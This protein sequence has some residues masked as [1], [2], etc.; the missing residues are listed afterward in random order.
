MDVAEVMVEL[1]KLGTEQTKKTWLR[2]GASG[3][4]FGVKI[5]DMKTL[6]KQL[7][8]G[9]AKEKPARQALALGLWA[10]G[11]LDAMYFAALLADGALMTR[12][13]LEQWVASARWQMLAEY[14]VAWVAAENGAA[15]EIA[16]EWIDSKKPN[17][18]CAGWNT[19]LGLVATRPDAALDLKEIER[20]LARIEKDVATAP[21]RVRYCMNGFV[22]AVG[23]YV[24]PLLAKAKATA[25][26]LGAVRVDVGDTDC[27]VPNALEMIEKIESM[28]RVGKKRTTMKC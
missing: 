27:K 2:H 24:K 28:G 11:N 3:E 6:M 10:T 23:A 8:K 21:N 15:R 9:N 18:A 22:M 4:L 19:Y 17:V 20:L 26:K 12:K 14:S 25:K 1:E 16:L 13:Q 7:P 5:G